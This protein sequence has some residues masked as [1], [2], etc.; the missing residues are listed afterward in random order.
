MGWLSDIAGIGSL[1]GGVVGMFADDDEPE[2]YNEMLASTREAQRLSGILSDPNSPEFKARETEEM[3][4]L[5]R[6]F[7]EGVKNWRTQVK[8]ERA[9]NWG[10]WLTDPERQDETV[11]KAFA[12]NRET[13]RTKARDNVR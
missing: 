1:V 12:R 7:A 5:N 10:T 3:G 13:L 2:G 8:R 6:E 11:E 4:T 9:R